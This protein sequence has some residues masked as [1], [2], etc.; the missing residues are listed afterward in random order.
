[1][2]KTQLELMRQHMVEMQ[3]KRRGIRDKKILDAFAK[4]PR[5]RF[6]NRFQ[7]RFAYE[8][9]PLPIGSGQTISQPY[10]VALMSEA[11]NLEGGEKVLEIGTGSGYQTA[12]LAEIAGEV[13]TVENISKLQAQAKG[14]LD[15]IGYDNITF[16]EGDGKKGYSES[17]PYDAILVTA[18][19]KKIPKDLYEQLEEGG[20]MVIPLGGMFMQSLYRIEKRD[21]SYDKH[22]LG[23]VRFVPL[24]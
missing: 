13:F 9:H 24:R 7:R 22:D 4:V 5:H 17:A 18:A 2:K 14:T 23:G 12:I 21:G 8:D 11:L 1:M 3:L 10:I 19:A 16:I 15:D 20:I 6:V